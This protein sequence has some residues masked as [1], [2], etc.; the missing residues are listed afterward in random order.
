MFSPRPIP[1]S[2]RLFLQ[3]PDTQWWQ[4]DWYQ[5]KASMALCKSNDKTS[6]DLPGDR[7]RSGE[8]VPIWKIIILLPRANW[9]RTQLQSHQNRGGFFFLFWGSITWERDVYKVNK[10]DRFYWLVSLFLF[11]QGFISQMGHGYCYSNFERKMQRHKRERSRLLTQYTIVISV[12]KKNGC[13]LLLTLYSSIVAITRVHRVD[14]LSL[15]L[16]LSKDEDFFSFYLSF[17]SLL[18]LA[19]RST[20]VACRVGLSVCLASC[21]I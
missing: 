5:M 9:A 13:W 2:F 6:L 1:S 7:R 10:F 21:L 20:V 8:G 16:W 14:F 12:R 4:V 3:N 11:V 17:F 18:T 19:L 15:L